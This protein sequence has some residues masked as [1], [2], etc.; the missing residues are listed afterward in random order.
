L[1]LRGAALAPGKQAC[2][3]PQPEMGG[4]PSSDNEVGLSIYSF[5]LLKILYKKTGP[6]GER[7]RLVFYF[8]LIIKIDFIRT[9]LKVFRR[10]F[11]FVLLI[12]I[13]RDSISG[14]SKG[15]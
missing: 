6:L 13:R 9:L 3:V 8:I 5:F 10:A 14:S 2:H 1:G 15:D 7:A 11:L 12:V 4:A